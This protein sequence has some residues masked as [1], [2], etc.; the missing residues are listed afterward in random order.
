MKVLIWFGFIFANAL[1]Q[2]LLG[3]RLGLIPTI[4]SFGAT[5]YMANNFSFRYEN[6][7]NKKSEQYYNSGKGII[8][9]IVWYIA[10]ILFV[11]LGAKFNS[12]DPKLFNAELQ[13]VFAIICISFGIVV[14]L[15]INKLMRFPSSKVNDCKADKIQ[16]EDTLVKDLSKSNNTKEE[17]TNLLLKYQAKVTV[18]TMEANKEYQPNNE[19]DED[20]GLIPEK[21]IFTFALKSVD[22]EIEYLDKL[23]TDKGEKIKYARRGSISVEGINGMIDIYDTFIPSGE[24]YKTIYINMYGA[25]T[26]ITTPKGFI[27]SE[28]KASV[29]TTNP[30]VENKKTSTVKKYCS[31][32]GHLIDEETKKC[33]GCGKQYIKGIRYFLGKIFCKKNIVLL[34][35]SFMLLVS[36]VANILLAVNITDLDRAYHI[37]QEKVEKYE[38]L[39]DD[40]QYEILGLENDL[41]FYNK[42]VVF[43]SDDGTKLYHKVDCYKFDSTYFWAYNTEYAIYLGYSP[44]SWCCG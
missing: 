1:I 14:T 18:D 44:C 28:K 38:G 11:F 8:K 6:R 22:G 12:S 26:S 35:L 42:Y 33:T 16:M 24:P 7:K 34:I 17:T 10:S 27:F 32:C 39:I 9:G 23:C 37:N 21:P 13:L 30:T 4:L 25:K 15:I 43:V 41:Y 40:Y 29:I 3:V 5:M 31:R 36:L 2:T 20:F 19:R